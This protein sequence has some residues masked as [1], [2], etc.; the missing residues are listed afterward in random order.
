MNDGVAE[1]KITAMPFG[2][3]RKRNKN[4]TVDDVSDGALQHRTTTPLMKNFVRNITT[5]KRARGALEEWKEFIIPENKQQPWSL[6]D[7]FGSEQRRQEPTTKSASAMTKNRDDEFYTFRLDH[8]QSG[9]MAKY[10]GEERIL[11]FRNDRP[12]A[13]GKIIF[14]STPPAPK[15]AKAEE[16]HMDMAQA[17]IHV[18]DVKEP[19]RGFGLG[20]L[21]CTEAVT[22]LRHRHDNQQGEESFICCQLEAEEDCRRHNKL[23]CF[24]QDMGFHAKPRAKVQYINNNDGETYRK[25]TMQRT[26]RVRARR[27]CKDC[28]PLTLPSWYR[29]FLPIQIKG[30]NGEAAYLNSCSRMYLVDAGDG[31]FELRITHRVRGNDQD[32]ASTL[33]SDNC[34]DAWSRFRLVQFTSTNKLLAHDSSFVDHNHAREARSLLGSLWLLQSSQGSFLSVDEYHA[35]LFCTK[36]LS[37]WQTE[38]VEGNCVLKCTSDTPLRRHYY[39]LK[40]ATQSVDYV[41]SMRENYLR[42]DICSMTLKEALDK[43]RFIDA[44]MVEFATAYAS[45]SN[46]CS[47]CFHTA[48]WLRR[49]GEP[50]WVQF[51]GLVYSL[52]RVV[53]LIEPRVP[54]HS[55]DSAHDWTISTQDW[56]LGCDLLPSCV[57]SELSWA[58][59]DKPE[60]QK[61]IYDLSCGLDNVLMTW[62]S[63]E[64]VAELFRHNKVIFP[65]EALAMLRLAS[66]RSWHSAGKYK[67]LSNDKDED[68]IPFVADF[69]EALEQAQFDAME[70]PT[71]EDKD[72]DRLWFHYYRAIAEKY[73]ADGILRW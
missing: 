53:K 57:S 38:M 35:N 49:H 63:Q 24:Y 73:G 72:C 14:S 56:V 48:E 18:L 65:E 64:Y 61:E 11:L 70:R 22:R 34:G 46:L 25:V 12:G 30:P 62:S 33:S 39:S 29:S 4:K 50:D 15:H 10:I 5:N 28:E 1:N 55:E 32:L 58:D 47:F 40:C 17:K 67:H 8:R 6:Q 9:A 7:L 26:I 60:T 43:A 51:L 42:F 44:G 66:L 23:V 2:H 68:L 54:S 69:D 16:D 19:Y 71:L 45:P 13:I 31:T 37:F 3:G 41:R 52:G 36:R 27:N 20:N 59:Q 21:L